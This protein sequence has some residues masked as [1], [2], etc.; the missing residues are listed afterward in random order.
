MLARIADGWMRVRFQFDFAFCI[1]A[2]SRMK[3]HQLKEDE[4]PRDIPE[5]VEV[6]C[7]LE[8]PHQ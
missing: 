4:T 6:I 1:F 2:F 7:M 5:R 8:T 3:N